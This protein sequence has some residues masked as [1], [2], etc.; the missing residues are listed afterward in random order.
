MLVYIYMETYD[1]IIIGGGA[2]G[3]MAAITAAE[4]NKKVLILEKNKRLG[5]KLR[6]SGGGRCN[7]T[8]DEDDIRTFLKTYTKTKNADQFLFS[9]F[10]QFDKNDTFAFF[11][12]RGLPLVVEARKRAFPHTQKAVDVVE[13]LEKYLKEKN[14]TIKTSSPV[15]KIHTKE[16][17]IISV[18]TQNTEYTAT[19]FIL[20]TGGVSHPETGS[21]GDG[22]NWLRD[23]GHTIK[24]PTPSIVPLAVKEKYIKNLSG[25]SLSFMKIA[26]YLDGVK[27]FTKKGKILFTHFGLS[28]PLILN[29]ACEVHDL[30]YAGE[31]TATI[32]MYPD[33]EIGSLDTQIVK[34]FDNNK[35]KMFKNM[36]SECV[37]EGMGKS[38][39]D[40]SPIAPDTK[41]HSI[42][43]EDRRKF[44]DFLKGLP[45][46]ITGLM[47]YDRA[48]V[49]DGGVALTEV[50]S[51]TM[52]SKVLDNLF[53][54]GDLLDINRPSGGFSL[55]LC[56]TTGYVAGKHA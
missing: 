36:L 5:E 25:I 13:T 30:L 7:I 42:S 47:G 40:V 27:K 1:V 23:L 15:T 26:F 46:T 39:I 44:V 51:K 6:I 18:A 4:Q 38:L 14:V 24:E 22:F 35:N 19:S 45:L 43:K 48:V 55:Q 31:V 21:T 20:A 8:N 17:S 34:I 53:I 2:S 37:P 10:S 52:R 29:S 32:D 49:A 50:D 28:G 33:T 54:T 56:W 11:K 12:S 9:A 3:M 16:K 41:V